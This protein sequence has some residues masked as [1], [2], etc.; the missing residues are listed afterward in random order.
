M[1]NFYSPVCN[2]DIL[3][4]FAFSFK[5]EIMKKIIAW[6]I[7]YSSIIH[8]VIGLIV[9]CVLILL[10]FPNTQRGTHYNYSVGGFWSENDLVAPYDFAILKSP[11]AI[12]KETALAKSRSLLY[13]T[14][15]STAFPGAVSALNKCE[16]DRADRQLLKSMLDRI[17]RKG[18]IE[19]PKEFELD[20]QSHTLVLLDG[21]VGQ[22]RVS[23]DFVSEEDVLTMLA[24]AVEDEKRLDRL[25]E[26]L[27][28]SI[29]RYSVVYDAVRTKLELDSRLSQSLYTANMVMSGSLIVAKGQYIT[30]EIAQ[31]IASLE[32][33]NTSRFEDH[34]SA[35]NH[36][37]GQFLLCVIA[38]LALYMFMKNTRHN[39]LDDDKKVTFVF[40]IVLFMSAI[41]ALIVRINPSW[42]LLVPLCIA[43][44]LMRVFFDM[45]VALYIHLTIV[46]IL[47]NLVPNSFE[48]IFYQ[49][50]TGM[51]SIIS[52]KGFTKR[53]N[54]FL[55]A[56]VI[57]LTYSMIYTAGILS[58]NT[59]W[60]SL[61][62]DRYLMFLINAVLTLLAY[63]MIYLF[64]KLFGMTTDLTLLEISSTNTP[65]LRELARNASGTFQ[66]CMQ[67]AN[68]SEDLIS[69]IGGNALLAR[70][71]ALYHDIGKIKAPL[72]F[73]ENQNNGFNP[74]DD[75]DYEESARIIT[76]HVRDGIEL[77]KKYGLPGDVIEFIR[78]HHGTTHTGYFYT[79]WMQE[80]PDEECDVTAFQY[81]GP[82]PFSRETAIV[83]IADSVEAASKSL[84]SLDKESVGR[85][86]DGI[87]DS[88]IREGQ[89]SNCNLT[90]A[91]IFRVREMLKTKIMSIYHVRI[92][93][94]TTK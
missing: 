70:V 74:H 89:L 22:E 5:I 16:I 7:P 44:I 60:S 33:E 71:G 23:T 8:K 43:P 29:L 46:I 49:L 72:Y 79:K 80:H 90:M 1:Q 63:P 65:A 62:G 26:L 92:S 67:V 59:S 24:S 4:K 86:V 35:F 13:Y 6:I 83:M 73:T 56:L 40:V 37:M 34:Y 39:I 84:K 88:K 25:G 19:T 10:M 41:T 61:Q 36:N 78:T 66:H 3:C 68:I 54:F 77:G 48:F 28:D 18:Y 27:M 51:M 81:A 14:M 53:S 21:N 58:Q 94:P 76:Q 50:I 30:E 32:Q 12:E 55:V 2:S 42:V 15:D 69:E 64:E 20:L 91:D 52:V 17:Y 9:T 38:F 93:Y 85:L 87:I 11:D 31:V 45:R 75:L 57:F 47:G 82:R